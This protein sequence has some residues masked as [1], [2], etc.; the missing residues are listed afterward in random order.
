MKAI[1]IIPARYAS[2]RF[3]GKPLADLGGRPVIEWV[4]TGVCGIDGIDEVCVATDDERIAEAVRRFG[5]V[6]IMT[7]GSHRSGTERCGEVVEKLGKEGKH[8]DVVLNV[9]GDEPFVDKTQIATLLS[10]FGDSTVKIA[11]LAKPIT[12][13]EELDSPNNV[14]V[15]CRTNGD[16]LYFSRTPVPYLRECDHAQWFSQHAFLK[17]IGLYAYRAETLRKITSLDETPLELCERLEQLRWLENGHPIKVL[18]T[19][20]DN[21]GIDTPDDLEAARKKLAETK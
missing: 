20:C 3:P 7:A 8:F 18:R 14:K 5:G 21:I 13:Q 9:Q 15:V 2:S 1:A 6:S 16:A 10:A 12:S 19:D 4:Y 17:H 11:T